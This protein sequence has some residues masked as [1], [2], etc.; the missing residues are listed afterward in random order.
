MSRTNDLAKVIQTRLKTVCSNVYHKNADADALYPHLV[1]SISNIDISDQ[2]RDDH[3]LTIDVWDMS[4]SSRIINDLCDDIEDLFHFQNLPQGT[5]LPT[6]F[7]EGRNPV[8]DPDKKI[9]HEVMR[10][11]I[12]NYER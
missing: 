3:I 10:F 4:T 9:R 7:P 2:N 12:Q 5:I 6:F 1:W 11:S 8:E